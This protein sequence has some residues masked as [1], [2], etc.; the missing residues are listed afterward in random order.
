MR[1]KTFYLLSIVDTK[2]SKL[3]KPVTQQ[4]VKTFQRDGFVVR[5]NVLSS[6]QVDAALNS[7][8]RLFKGDY[9]TGLMPDEVNWRPERDAQDL[10]RQICN[11]WKS[12]PTLAKI[13]LDE[14]LGKTCAALM[15]WPGTRLNQDNIFWKPP[16]GKALGF[17][18]DSSYEQ[19]VTPDDM[20]SCWIAL[21]DTQAQGGTVEYVRGSHL[22]ALEPMIKTFHAPDDPLLEMQQ[23]AKRAG[24]SDPDITAIEVPA[25]SCVF[26]HGY[27]WHGSQTNHLEKPRRSIVAH[28]MSSA[29]RFSDQHT[30]AVYSRYQRFGDTAMD[31]SFFPILWRNDGY[32]STFLDAYLNQEIGWGGV[33]PPQR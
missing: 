27:T 20:V 8:Q 6:T 30:G 33:K 16:G 32:R 15:A 12:D 23:A 4:E 25:G 2:D 31:E 22:W 9:Q 7:I 18:Q 24:V 21:D 17:H 10:T 3:F 28:C 29:A 5:E 11:G 26:H 14:S 1:R 19:W 13:L